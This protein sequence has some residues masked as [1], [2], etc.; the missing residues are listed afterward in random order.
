MYQRFNFSIGLALAGIS[1]IGLLA[2]AGCGSGNDST[3]TSTGI[4]TGIATLEQVNAGRAL[5]INNGC[6]DC[7]SQGVINPSAAVWLAGGSGSPTGAGPGDF[8]LGPL[9]ITH[10]VNLTP[11][12][13]NGAIYASTDRQVFNVLKWGLDPS[14][15]NA[16]KVINSKADFPA[17]PKY[18][19]P[20]MP[21]PA[22][23]HKP[24]DQLW[25][26]VAYLK[27]GL[28]AN[29]HAVP[30]SATSADDWRGFYSADSSPVPANS[31]PTAQEE[32]KP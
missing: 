10:A 11:D 24:D 18:V 23:R 7:H 17:T 8:N 14:D 26:I 6:G 32:F 31:Y 29:P 3:T 13:T 16:N 9:G 27:H 4:P 28:K 19:A 1:S 15:P 22:Y 21:W 5:V 30:E 20:P 12:P 25:A 2:L